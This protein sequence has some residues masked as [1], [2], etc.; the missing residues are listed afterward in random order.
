M[1][2]NSLLEEGFI[3]F[4]SFSYCPLESGHIAVKGEG[5][6]WWRGRDKLKES[7]LMQ[8]F[9]LL[10]P[11]IALGTIQENRQ[12]RQNRPSFIV[13]RAVPR[14][15]QSS[16]SETASSN[17]SDSPARKPRPRSIAGTLPSAESPTTETRTGRSADR[18]R[19]GMH[20]SV[21]M[22]LTTE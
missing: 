11:L 1:I 12:Y 7:G 14:R 17:T 6:G 18:G 20:S 4:P 15:P 10:M 21:C 22:Q 19:T 2:L 3:L 13:S 9:A 8:L 16:Q 5:S